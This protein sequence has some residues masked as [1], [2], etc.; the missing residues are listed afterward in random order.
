MI[1]T[2]H[3]AG[4]DIAQPVEQVFPLFSPEGEKR[5]VPHW[6]YENVMGTTELSEDYVFLTR[7]HD[8]AATDA[9]WLVKRYVPEAWFIQYYRVEPE[10][11]IGVVTVQCSQTNEGMTH[12]EVSYRYIALSDLGRKFVERFT[13]ECYEKV[14]D[15]WRVLLLQYFDSAA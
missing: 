15:E 13:L 5:W 2:K 8:H 7:S 4:F 10:D 3:S 14:I 1:S 11:K 12:V 9:I 6:D